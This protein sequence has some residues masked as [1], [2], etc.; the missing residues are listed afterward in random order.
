MHW[1]RDNYTL[2]LLPTITV[3]WRIPDIERAK[4]VVSWLAWSLW[5]EL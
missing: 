5:V 1:Y 4:L 2:E 3:Q